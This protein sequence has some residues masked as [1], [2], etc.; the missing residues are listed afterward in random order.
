MIRGYKAIIGCDY[1]GCPETVEVPAEE[2]DDYDYTHISCS[3]VPEGWF[4]EGGKDY[5]PE[6][7][8]EPYRKRLKRLERMRERYRKSKMDNL[9]WVPIDANV[10]YKA[11]SNTL[12]AEFPK[13]GLI[14]KDSLKS[15]AEDDA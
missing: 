11:L 10:Y 14:K 13:H 15:L 12:S 2:V 6:H 4:E 5:C 1:K 3:P 9:G 8:T 7:A